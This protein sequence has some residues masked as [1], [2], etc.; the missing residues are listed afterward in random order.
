MRI[1]FLFFLL[2]HFFGS[3]I[4]ASIG[5]MLFHGALHSVFPANHRS[6]QRYD[7]ERSDRHDSLLGRGCVEGKA[8]P[9]KRDQ[10]PEKKRL[11]R[12]DD[13]GDNGPLDRRYADPL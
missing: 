13:F 5:D 12:A 1:L 8:C 4:R 9:H 2:M 10:P 3:S 11:E 7:K 6:E